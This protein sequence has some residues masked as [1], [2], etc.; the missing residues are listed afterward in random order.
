ME[1]AGFVIAAVATLIEDKGQGLADEDV[2][3]VFPQIGECT[4]EQM[5]G[6]IF[7]NDKPPRRK[8]DY[9]VGWYVRRNPR[10]QDVWI[11]RFGEEL[12]ELADSLRKQLLPQ[13]ETKIY[14][15]GDA[16]LDTAEL[17]RQLAYS[18]L[19]RKKW[20]YA[21]DEMRAAVRGDF[22]HCEFA[23]VAFLTWN[24][25]NAYKVK[26]VEY[27]AK[28]VLKAEQISGLDSHHQKMLEDYRGV[29][30]YVKVQGG[31]VFVQE[32]VIL[33]TH[34]TPEFVQAFIQQDVMDAS[35]GEVVPVPLPEK[36]PVRLLGWRELVAR[37]VRYFETAYE[38][39]DVDDFAWDDALTLARAEAK[40]FA[41]KSHWLN[42]GG[43][44]EDARKRLA[45]MMGQKVEE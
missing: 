32:D 29:M 37:W 18:V 35:I 39:R 17:L 43:Y 31:M 23:S 1:S 34:Y 22:Q 9:A 42:L 19:M 12:P 6:I 27:R 7:Y 36:V 25:A 44:L 38:A 21:G 30:Q 45:R 8:S 40:A 10:W 15:G 14:H 16:S 26:E 24:E 3:A 28:Y 41:E 2:R 33:E 13:R 4:A 20:S 11:K 5:D